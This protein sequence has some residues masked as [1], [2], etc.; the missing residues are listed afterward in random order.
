M[1]TPKKKR[2]RQSIFVDVPPYHVFIPPTQQYLDPPCKGE[3][4]LYV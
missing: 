1:A 4:S 3:Y 2:L